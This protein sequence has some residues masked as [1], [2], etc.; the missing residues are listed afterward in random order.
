MECKACDEVLKSVESYLSS[1]QADLASVSEEIESLQTRS[2]SLNTK[3]ENRIVV[4]SHLGPAVEELSVPPVIVRK[5][6]EGLIDG[7]FETG[8]GEIEKRTT[9]AAAKSKET[10]VRAH[11]DIQVLLQNLQYKV[12]RSLWL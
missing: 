4:E 7:D 11:K 5:I 3:L 12:S 1:F 2:A 10:S 6:T 8:L 9:R